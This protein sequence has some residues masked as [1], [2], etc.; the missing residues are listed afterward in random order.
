MIHLITVGGLAAHGN[1]CADGPSRRQ[2]SSD[3]RQHS[4]QQL[5]R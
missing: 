1:L 5:H 3:P 4:G 2:N